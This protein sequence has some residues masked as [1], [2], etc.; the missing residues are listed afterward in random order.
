MAVRTANL[1]LAPIP[2]PDGHFGSVS[3]FDFLEHVPR[4]LATADGSTT[5]FPFVKLMHEIWR[6][7]APAGLFYAIT[8]GFPREEA[9][10]DPT[11]V[12]YLSERSHEYFCGESP[13][14]RMYGFAG[15]FRIVRTRWV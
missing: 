14:G 1:A 15:E 2:W 13:L 9:F 8:P 4:V 11:H 7:L 10:R 5:F 6:V 3:A 12:N